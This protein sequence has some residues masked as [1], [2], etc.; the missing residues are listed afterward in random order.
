MYIPYCTSGYPKYITTGGHRHS[1]CLMS[2]EENTLI[3]SP[4][5]SASGFE[6]GSTSG[7][8]SASASGSEPAHASGSGS[9]SAT[10]SGSHEKAASFDEAISLGEVPVPRSY[11]P[12]SVAG[13]PK[14][15]CVE[16]Q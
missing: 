6:A 11:N 4:A 9:G 14:I 10:G 15:L 16:G 12:N 2:D 7:S 5:G 13:E 3:G 1:H 8:E